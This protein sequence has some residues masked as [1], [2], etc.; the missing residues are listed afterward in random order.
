[1]VVPVYGSYLEH[2]SVLELCGFIVLVFGTLVFNEIL[3]LPIL[4][5]DKYTKTALAQA[6]AHNDHSKLLDAEQTNA[7]YVALSPHHGYDATRNQ[8]ALEAHQI[9]KED[10]T[11]Q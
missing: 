7:D 4:G 9:N 1:M 3:I 6:Q 2:F 11:M 10:S 8:R 5:F